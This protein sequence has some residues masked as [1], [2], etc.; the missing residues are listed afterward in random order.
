MEPV[1]GVRLKAAFEGSAVTFPPAQPATAIKT[2]GSRKAA[3][4]SGSLVKRRGGAHES[5]GI[6]AERK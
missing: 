1:P 6:R 2:G 3:I 5:A 4:R